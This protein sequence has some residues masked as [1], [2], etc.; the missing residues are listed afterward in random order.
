[1]RRLDGGE[2]RGSSQESSELASYT[3]RRTS[4]LGGTRF[5][6]P[7]RALTLTATRMRHITNG[8]W[9]SCHPIRTTTDSMN[10]D[11]AVASQLWERST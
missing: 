9:S 4:V 1:M 5:T 2:S 8:R 10:R 3:T 6:S 7:S 11:T